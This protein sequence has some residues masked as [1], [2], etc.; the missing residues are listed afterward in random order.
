[1]SVSMKSASHV[2]VLEKTSATNTTSEVGVLRAGVLHPQHK[3]ILAMQLEDDRCVYGYMVHIIGQCLASGEPNWCFY[4][5]YRVTIPL[6]GL[7]CSLDRSC[8]MPSCSDPLC[9]WCCPK[10]V[11]T[12][13]AGNVEGPSRKRKLGSLKNDSLIKAKGLLPKAVGSLKAP[14]INAEAKSLCKANPPNPVTPANGHWHT[15]K[16]L[17]DVQKLF[18]N[19]SHASN[20]PQP[21]PRFLINMS[22]GDQKQV[23]NNW[24]KNSVFDPVFPESNKYDWQKDEWL[25]GVGKRRRSGLNPDD[26]AN[27]MKDL[28]NVEDKKGADGVHRLVWDFDKKLGATQSLAVCL[29]PDHPFSRTLG[30]AYL[31]SR[32][33]KLCTAR[34]TGC[35]LCNNPYQEPGN[36]AIE[37]DENSVDAV[38]AFKRF[39]ANET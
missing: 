23:S 18:K 30:K 24:S 25:T 16:T 39:E 8:Q 11:S 1:M 28:K 27:D 31:S 13:K 7:P 5:R 21:G 6:A 26:I 34:M 17:G 3:D 10:G 29:N 19:Y 22:L 36:N 2:F 9:F 33:E 20:Q 12:N 38:E 32:V 14:L 37:E 35:T 15:L 4:N